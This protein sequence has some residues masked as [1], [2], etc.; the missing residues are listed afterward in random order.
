VT[1]DSVT[2]TVIE[3]ALSAAADEMFAV[4]KKTAMSPI[5]YEVLD[6]G[7]GITDATGRLVSSGAGIPTF[8]GALDKA[9]THILARH[10]DTIRDGDLF[11]TN[12][13]HDGGVTH[14]NDMVV[15]L[16]IFHDGRLAAW[17]AS[18]AHYSDIGGRT[19]GSMAIDAT[20]IWAEG[21]RI[22]ATRLFAA[23]QLIPQVLDILT[24]NSRQPELLQGDLWAQVAAARRAATRIT[25]TLSRYGRT[26]FDAALTA[27][28]AQGEARARAGLSRLPPGHYTIRA[29]QDD[30]P[31]W[32]AAIT[33]T[34]DAMTIDLRDAPP[35]TASPWNLS[36]DA[37][38]IAAQMIFKATA[39]PAR[40]TNAGTFAPLTVLTTPGTIFHALPPA[41]QAYYFE[42]RIRLLDLLWRCLAQAMP[43]RL[44]AGHFGTIGGVVIAGTHP[45]TGRR[46]TMVEP[47]MGGWGAT[48]TRDG[49][50]AMFSA[51]HGETFT[52]PTEIAEARYGLRITRR[53]LSDTPGGAGLHHGGRGVE[54]DITLHAPATLSAGFSH[55]RTPVWGAAGG[56]SGGLNGLTHTRADGTATSHG[57]I[58]G[59]H[60]APGDSVTIRTAGGGGWGTPPA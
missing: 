31:D 49:L 39:D 29:S 4:L 58:S 21:L 46:Y 48:A 60:L 5:I 17:A 25:A 57:A 54:T 6:C 13:P 9:V 45:D 15:A 27:A 11:L 1:P 50:D 20:E 19:P 47:Q 14:L 51:S 43:D 8:V 33:I 44:P 3:S 56:A 24:V 42:T 55:V 28:F 10:G 16:P 41:P 36:R 30:G 2:L 40:D 34:P 26:T 37:A 18:M 35:Q 38:T 32:Q 22:P 23:G 52:C 53:A 7:T 12:D 59:L